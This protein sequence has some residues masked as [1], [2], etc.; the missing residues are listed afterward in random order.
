MAATDLTPRKR[1]KREQIRDGAR[2]LFLERGFARTNTDAIAKEAGVSK[3]TLYVYYPSK[4]DLLEDVL[5]GLVEEAP[6]GRLPVD[7]GELSL[8][9]RAELEAALGGLAERMIST[10]MQPEY[11]ALMRVLVAE[12]PALPHLGELYRSTVPERAFRGVTGLLEHAV[13]RGV[14]GVEDVDAAS[15]MFVGSLL[16]YAILD[17]LFV[18]DG[19]PRKPSEDRL[20]AIVALFMKTIAKGDE[21]VKPQSG[22][23]NG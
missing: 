23:R 5:R 2:R 11:V 19:P 3:Q 14:A 17:G 9:D 8:D 16:T 13:D 1:A 20:A 21:G 12:T 4:E 15:R 6:E 7:P 10:I 18:V 22:R